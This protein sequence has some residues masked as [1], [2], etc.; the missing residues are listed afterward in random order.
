MLFMQHALD[1]VVQLVRPQRTHVS[2]PRPI[3][4]QSRVRQQAVES[5]VLDPVDLQREEQETRRYGVQAFLYALVEL[6]G[7]RVRLVARIDELSIAADLREGLVDGLVF[8][9]GAAQ[10]RPVKR[11]EPALVALRELRRRRRGTIQVG[12]ELCRLRPAVKIAQIPL[13]QRA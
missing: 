13:R 9:N 8:G 4:G 7:R 12:G 2:Q 11:C 6:A 10:R 1:F 3:A 5:L